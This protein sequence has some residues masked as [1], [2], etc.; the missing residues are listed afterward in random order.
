MALQVTKE[1]ISVE[2]NY[3]FN[4]T[5]NPIQRLAMTFQEKHLHSP[6]NGWL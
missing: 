2:L 6:T 1:S 4:Y 5:Y 3:T